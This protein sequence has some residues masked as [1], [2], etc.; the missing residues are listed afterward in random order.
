VL[1]TRIGIG[2]VFA[3]DRPALVHTLLGSCV[4]AC[5]FDPVAAIGGMNHFLLPDSPSDHTM[6]TRYGVHA[7]ER[8]VNEIMRRGG[9]RPRVRAK[10]FGAAHV[11]GPDLAGI[12]VPE[13]NARFVRTFLA[14]EGIPVVAER[15][16]G[17]AAVEVRFATHTGQAFVRAIPHAVRDV[18]C[19]ERHFRQRVSREAQAPARPGDVTLF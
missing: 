1:V 2:D 19:R 13:D 17:E 8:L 15:L 9:Q 10:V 12:H 4:A 5:L 7:M 16:G 6:P 3:S 14:T 18:A 11:L